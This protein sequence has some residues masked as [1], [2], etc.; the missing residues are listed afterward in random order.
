[1]DKRDYMGMFDVLESTLTDSMCI[2][3]G[4]FCVHQ[5]ENGQVDI[6]GQDCVGFEGC[7]KCLSEYIRRK[8][9]SVE[10]QIFKYAEGEMVECVENP[11]GEDCL[12]VGEQYMVL[13]A[14][15]IDGEV[16]YC[17]RDDEGAVFYS[18]DHFAS[19]TEPF[20][21]SGEDYIE[22]DQ[23]HHP[24]H[25]NQ[26]P[27][28]VIDLIEIATKEMRG[29]QAVCFGN[30]IKYILRAPF[31]GKFTEDLQKAVFYIN[32]MLSESE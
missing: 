31:K 2:S 15:T 17:L 19:S 6:F 1:M 12:R 26:Y 16:V 27:T 29:I 8:E 32:K 5:T 11:S 13:G 10:K 23:V 18:I 7:Y 9:I 28:E 3:F 20:I 22:Y 21:Y 24:V 14:E 30:A 25:Y 4:N